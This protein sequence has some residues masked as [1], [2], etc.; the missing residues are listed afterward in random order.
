MSMQT[1]HSRSFFWAWPQC[2]LR[3]R[4]L[5]SCVLVTV[6]A[7]TYV[8]GLIGVP[9]EIGTFNSLM[10]LFTVM[11][12]L[13]L[14]LLLVGR[15]MYLALV[16]RPERPIHQMVA[17]VRRI[18][19][20]FE[21][22]SIGMVALVVFIVFIRT[23]SYLK[24]AIPFV[25]PF[26]W[27]VTFAEWDRMLHFGT[28]PYKIVLDLIG[29]PMVATGVNAAYHGWLFLLYFSVI[30][31]CF[32]RE[33]RATHYRYLTAFVLVWFGG[34]NVVAMLLS[35][36]GPVYYERLGFGT[37]F[38]ALTD[39]L[40]DYDAVGRIWALDVH[41]MLW[42]GY[43]AEGRARGISAMPSMHVASSVL[44]M[45]YAYTY[46]RWAGRI[47]AVF[48]GVIMIGSVMLAWH[49]AIDGYLGALISVL[50]WKL[51]GWMVRKDGMA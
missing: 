15:F 39:T 41:E 14:I 36:A 22:M 23:F 9:F 25:N 1:E 16:L 28:D 34:G 40:K 50:G 13:F 6:V 38:V 21:R 2:L 12:P 10:A 4:L 31:A 17:D 43:V 8:S 37:D 7:A 19:F 29:T 27:D 42:D 11:L 44:M 33:N 45:L 26:S 48:V 47:M 30:L 18:F 49:Y 20:D 51:A 35:S 3:N 24:Y 46:G 32:S 5:I